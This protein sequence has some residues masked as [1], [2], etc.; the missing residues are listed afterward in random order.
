MHG[1]ATT[2]AAPARFP[3]WVPAG[4]AVLALAYLPTLAA[5]FDFIDDGDLVYPAP[6]GTTFRQHANR[7][8]T[9]VTNNVDHLGPFRPVLW[10]HWYTQANLFDGD[11]LAWRASR[12][13]WCALAAGVLLWL[14]RELRVPPGAA[15]L[16]GAAAMWNP[17]RNEVWMS[18][19]L[20]EG[21]AMPYALLALVAAR[22]AVSATR[23]VWWDAVGV[24][25][26]LVALGCKNTFAALVPAQILLRVWPEGVTLRAGWHAHGRRALLFVLPLALPI[27][28][29]I[30]F[31]RHW[32]PGQYE[33]NGPSAAQFVRYLACL[34]GAAG[35]DFLG[36]GIAL[37]AVAV[38]WRRRREE[39]ILAAEEPTPPA[40]LPAGRGEKEPRSSIAAREWE[41]AP[42][43]FTPSL[44]GGGWGVGPAGSSRAFLCALA[45]C[46]R[47]G[48]VST[49]C[50]HLRPVR[51]ARRLGLDILFA[52]LLT[53]L[54]KR[55]APPAQ[56]HSQRCVSVSWR[57]C[58]ST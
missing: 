11:P 9:C 2:I 7:W 10:A 54:L 12:L 22:R 8:W 47:H 1:R 13:V 45:A 16:A 3:W 6:P 31:K 48:R 28:H 4:A 5:P 53:A 34:K 24:A 23:P 50:D 55:A 46:G 56:R 14:F 43:A 32:H 21:V 37:A 18:L 38:L 20:S 36:A 41:A 35:L 58:W 44:Q 42:R 30:Y 57:C 15:L 19:T 49:G 27:G 25:C 29:F 40:P 51:D 52:L 33:A 26:V 39:P 17:Y